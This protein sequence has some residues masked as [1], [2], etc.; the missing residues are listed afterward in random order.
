M[1]PQ[2]PQPIRYQNTIP[3]PQNI[4]QVPNPKAKNNLPPFWN[5][6]TYITLGSLI[7]SILAIVLMFYFIINGSSNAEKLSKTE[8]DLRVLNS[9]FEK[10]VKQK[11]G[12]ELSLNNEVSTHLKLAKSIETYQKLLTENI[13]LNNR[14]GKFEI[15]PNANAKGT[16]ILQ[17]RQ[18]VYDALTESNKTLNEASNKIGK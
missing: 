15:A 11:E 1:N 12:I 10:L 18:S 9:N 13:I 4:Q 3:T 16:E 2:K 17:A 8:N 6:Y 7:I 14:E 5:I